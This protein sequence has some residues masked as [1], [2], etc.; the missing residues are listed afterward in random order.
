MF[1]Q[2]ILFY[3]ISVLEYFQNNSLEM[4]SLLNF[5][6]TPIN[7]TTMLMFAFFVIISY[8]NNFICHVVGILYPL[9]YGLYVFNETPI[10]I[11]RFVIINKYWILFGTITLA[12]SLFGF[13]LHAIPG[14]FYLKIILIYVFVYNDFA[15]TNMGFNIIERYYSNVNVKSCVDNFLRNV[16]SKLRSISKDNNDTKYNDMNELNMRIR[17]ICNKTR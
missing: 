11:D 16:N 9:L 13:I 5:L 3:L 15:F 7:F 2:Q 17:E 8:A 6:K 14:Y 4:N 12:D 10:N 1:Y